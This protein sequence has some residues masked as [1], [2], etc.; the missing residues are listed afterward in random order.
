MNTQEL[1]QTK[2]ENVMTTDIKSVLENDVMTKVDALMKKYK[3]NHIPVVD[4]DNN[5]KGILTKNDILLMKDWG[6]NL[7]LRTAIKANDQILNSTTAGRRMNRNI[8]TVSPEDTLSKCATILK[9]NTFHA[10]PVVEDGRLVG[11][12]TTYDLINIAYPITQLSEN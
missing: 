10:L 2:V 4:D 9:E 3:F 7:Q 1:L 5:L 6:T 12:I 11:I 8:I